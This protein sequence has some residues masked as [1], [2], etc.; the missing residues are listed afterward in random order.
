MVDG[1]RTLVA[2]AFSATILFE[3]AV[4]FRCHAAEAPR[5][6]Q[7]S[8]DPASAP[9]GADDPC[10]SACVPDCYC[11]STPLTTSIVFARPSSLL[12]MVP[13]VLSPGPLDGVA[14]VPDL[15]PIA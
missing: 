9:G 15:P 4:D 13:E 14:A 11:C 12:V 6:S 5:L 8:S 7:V 1:V 2:I 3:P 10:G